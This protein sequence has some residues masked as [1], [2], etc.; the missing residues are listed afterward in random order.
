MKKKL[1][2]LN[3]IGLNEI[4]TQAFVREGYD[5]ISILQDPFIY[6][7]NIWTKLMNVY[8]RIILKNNNFYGE[9][10]YK[11]LDKEVY[12]RLKEIKTQV[13]Y[14]L[15]FRADY[16]SKKNIELLRKKSKKLITYQ[17]DG[18]ELGK[19][20]VKHKDYFDRV[21][22]F[23]KAD[24]SKFGSMALPL[25]NCYF[26]TNETQAPID[27]DIFYIGTGTNT[28]IKYIKN[29]YSRLGKK[30]KIKGLITIPDYQK[31]DK[32]GDIKF[33]HQ[34]LKYNDNIA[35]LRTSKC[36]IDIKFTYHDGLS[37]RFFEALYYKKKL[38][39]NNQSVKKYD[40]YH[41][42]N[43]FITDFENLDGIEEFLDKPY[44]EIDKKIVDK[45]G[46]TNWSRYVLDIHPYQEIKLP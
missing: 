8:Y 45:Y 12:K 32:W 5:V 14:T 17:Y 9:D 7:K 23:E 44:I 31:E 10:Y 34:G 2:L 46:F 29:L 21:F 18:W 6:K 15:V 33:S 42:N 39:T 28:R 30:I 20:I 13:D 41:P 38:I 35:L 19:G 4:F 25:T 16:Y 3:E 22:F 43:I 37:F 11:K 36:L 1:I 24:L 40:F 27:F 26:T